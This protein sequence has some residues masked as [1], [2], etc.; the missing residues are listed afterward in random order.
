MKQGRASINRLLTILASVALVT[1]VIM[2][3]NV[4]PSLAAGS[5]SVVHLRGLVRLGN[6]VLP[7]VHR[8]ALTGQ[9]I[10]SAPMSLSISLSG[11]DQNGL[12]RL[13]ANIENGSQKPISQEQFA[14]RFGAPRAQVDGVV[15]WARTNGLR[16]TYVSRDGM[17]IGVSG[18][19]ANV[20][21]A[22]RVKVSTFRLGTRQFYS[23]TSNP[24]LPARLG[25]QTIV[26]LNSYQRAHP[27]GLRRYA[28]RNGG[29]F[30]RDFR[31]AYDVS[32]HKGSAAGQTIGFTLWGAPE[33]NAD[34][35]KFASVTGDT[36]LVTCAATTS[37]AT[38][39]SCKGAHSANTV[40]WVQLDGKSNDIGGLGETALDVESAHGLAPNSHLKYFLGGDGAGQAIAD[41][42]SAAA[43]DKTLH[44]V[45]NSWGVNPVNSAKDPFA[46]ATT[47]S[48]KHAVAVGTTFFV[49]S[50]DSASDSGC[51][52]QGSKTQVTCGKP[53][54]P[55]DN[56]YVVAVGGTNLQVNNTATGYSSE[57]VWSNL[58]FGTSTNYN[59]QG[60][61]TGC[62]SFFARPSFQKN[63]QGVTANATCKGRAEP[64]VS[65]DADPTSGAL[66]V[67]TAPNAQKQPVQVTEDIG[68]TSLAAPLWT[69]MAADSNNYLGAHKKKPVGFWAPPIYR[70]AQTK[71]YNTYFHDVV[72]GYNGSPAS[73]GWDQATGWGSPDWYKL[74]EGLAGTPPAAT[75]KAPTNCQI[76]ASK[77]ATAAENSMFLSFSHWPSG[78][79]T[80]S[81]S[82]GRLNDSFVDA[83][84]TSSSCPKNFFRQFHG[85]SYAHFG[86][87]GGLGESAQIQIGTDTTPVGYFV[88]SYYPNNNDAANMVK[89]VVAHVKS[90]FKLTYFD[91]SV[92]L[93]GNAALTPD[94]QGDVLVQS[95][96]TDLILY[97]FAINNTVGELL[98]DV[99][100][101]TLQANVAATVKAADVLANNEIVQLTIASN[102]SA[103]SF[104]APIRHQPITGQLRVAPS[105]TTARLA[106]TLTPFTNR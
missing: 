15:T 12:N 106:R 30:P 9:R 63:V 36:K 57:S 32:Q 90:A 54:Y 5:P 29:Y 93:E 40:Q 88:G 80:K 26:G 98:L 34:L 19:T 51:P 66:V 74:T 1:G 68:G 82:A 105:R 75:G 31:A 87:K 67:H 97:I 44:L 6:E 50:G 4:A 101:A 81:E 56:P 100:D 52:R 55:A 16:V 78:V 79:V 71:Q 85:Q 64:D 47:N 49:S 28:F 70:L 58:Q 8:A 72:C 11:R 99:K 84:C 83:P 21:R 41:A 43:N 69:A 38:P 104:P 95:G 37:A 25:I 24:T 45:S 89:D 14:S 73:L 46:V 96:G 94:C 77:S 48:F 62:A 3:T 2:G 27:V 17:T 13:I 60:G 10:G 7:Q 76:P 22:L 102:G 91:C 59:V 86:F 65:A 18:A 39:A 23:T 35:A 42:V 33:N 53:S 92:N 103:E 20:E 61:G